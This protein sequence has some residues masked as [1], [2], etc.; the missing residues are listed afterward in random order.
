MQS[1]SGKTPEQFFS[2]DT[3]LGM[4]LQRSSNC[5]LVGALMIECPERLGGKEFFD[6][7]PYLRQ[8]YYAAESFIESLIWRK[9]ESFEFDHKSNF[10]ERTRKLL[11]ETIKENDGFY[12]LLNAFITIAS[13]P[14]HPFNAKWLHRW[15]WAMSMPKRDSIWS[16]FL[17][18]QHGQETSVDR[19]LEWAWSKQDK[20]HV[21]DEPLFL[22]C[23]ILAWFLTTSNR[24][25]RD[26]ATKGL[27]CLLT[28][29]LDL[30]LSLLAHFEHVN[31]P[32]VA[33]RLYA[34][35]YG[36]V[37]RNYADPNGTKNLAEWIYEHLFST[38]R[39]PAHILLRD[40]ARGVIE[41]AMRRKIKISIKENHIWPPYKSDWIGIPPSEEQLKEKY[42]PE[43]E[44]E[45]SKGMW[46]IWWSVIGGGDF[47]RYV[48]GT[49]SNYCAW[50]GRRF[51]KKEIDRKA[52]F[53]IFLNN[54]DKKQKQLW[55]KANPIICEEPAN[56]YAP[57]NFLRF[58]VAVGRK[59]EVESQI[60]LQRFKR[61]LGPRKANYYEKKNRSLS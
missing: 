56:E 28:N 3:Q 21:G 58:K 15:L 36:C 18:R 13:C 26:K 10:P 4:L 19:L 20:S 23:V 35:A 27:V 47:D 2:P 51:G 31:D 49:N 38:N 59:T 7:A 29:R 43:K 32:Y 11:H 53:E 22:L 37:L 50:S 61:S 6:V 46:R 41:V 1:S 52:A 30:L 42:N 40:Y 44:S 12:Y 39:P 48:I 14:N 25:V 55:D 33:E 5:G 54:L 60:A 9:P 57:D 17:H 24:A 8:K 34:V 45:G 16:V